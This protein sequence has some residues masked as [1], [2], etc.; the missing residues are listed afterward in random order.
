MKYLTEIIL[1]AAFT[2]STGAVTIGE[3]QSMILNHGTQEEFE[4]EFAQTGVSNALAEQSIAL[5][6]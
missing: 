5:E 3:E 1:A 2:S 4:L 6:N